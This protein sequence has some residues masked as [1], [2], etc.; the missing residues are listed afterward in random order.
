LVPDSYLGVRRAFSSA[1]PSFVT[2]VPPLPCFPE[3]FFYYR[4]LFF[5]CFQSLLRPPNFGQDA[6]TVAPRSDLSQKHH[7]EARPS[8]HHHFG[9]F[10][11]P[12]S[13]QVRFLIFRLPF[14]FP[15]L[16]VPPTLITPALSCSH[17][18][19]F[20]PP[21]ETNPFFF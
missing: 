11:P 10:P 16:W 12:L 9:N 5:F 17:V 13:P 4:S 7:Q 18:N 3:S 19:F 8:V 14:P 20:P 21:R 15:A 2:G 1:R 6:P